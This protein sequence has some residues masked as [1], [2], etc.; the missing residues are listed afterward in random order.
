[1]GVRLRIT[2]LFASIVLI[3]LLLVCGSVYFFS[4]KNRITNITTRLTNRAITTARLL[5]RSEYFDRGLVQRIDSATALSLLN[6]TIQAYD[7][8]D[9]CI[10]TYSDLT[11]DTLSVDTTILAKARNKGNSYFTSGN[12]DFIACSVQNN[13]SGIVMLIGAIDFEGKEKLRQ[14]RLILFTSFIGGLMIAVAGGYFFSGGLVRPIRKIAD[15]VSEI[16]AKNLSSRIEQGKIKDEWNY[17]SAT[18]NRL[19]NR[20]QDSFEVQQRFVAHASHE[21]CTPLTSISSQLEVSLQKDRQAA[22]YRQVMES[23][24][25]DVRHL[26]KLTQTLLEF[27]SAS[28]SAAGIV[29]DLIRVDEILLRMPAELSKTDSCYAIVL[30]FNE[31]PQEEEKLLIWGNEELLFSALNNIVINACKYSPDHKAVVKLSVKDQ[32]ISIA[33][34]D[35]GPGID[36]EELN[37]IFQ[38]FYRVEVDR[39][40]KGFGLGLSL[41]N[42]IIRLHKGYISTQSVIGE[43]ST[44]TIVL[45]AAGAVAS[46]KAVGQQQ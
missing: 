23:I 1:M 12:K 45:P 22:E 39:N 18:L 33:V 42:R 25:Q 7:A 32:Q 43:G 35:K 6:K 29:I 40:V 27:A 4:Y 15:E 10:Y 17:L 8:A 16:S 14:L 44:F 41:A 36:Q 34:Q 5:S 20:L 37:N 9:N 11:G 28:G 19:L 21:L 13:S 38:P 46:A 3:I 26:N 24:Y 2:L 30:L 31:L